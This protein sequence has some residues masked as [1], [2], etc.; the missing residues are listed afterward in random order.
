MLAKAGRGMRPAVLPD[1]NSQGP[2]IWNGPK[3]KT[4]LSH[5]QTYVTKHQQ[6]Y[7]H[8][9]IFK[10]KAVWGR[11]EPWQ[12]EGVL[13]P[14]PPASFLPLYRENFFQ[15]LGEGEIINTIYSALACHE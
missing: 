12:M 11:G 8:E 9:C 5:T 10:R 14:F 3:G 13:N 2:T 7:A 1:T 4:T 6:L 15:C